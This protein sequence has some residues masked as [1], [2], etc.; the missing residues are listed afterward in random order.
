MIEIRP[1]LE[2]NDIAGPRRQR[3]PEKPT[4]G[5]SPDLVPLVGRYRTLVI[6]PP[7]Y[8]R[9]LSIACSIGGAGSAKAALVHG[10]FEAMI[11]ADR[12]AALPRTIPSSEATRP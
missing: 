12:S 7:W 9:T 10:K 11:D 8:Y 1:D 3:E 5:A 2:R 4:P 6:K